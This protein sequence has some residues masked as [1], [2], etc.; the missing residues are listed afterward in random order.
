M[1]NKKYRYAT[2]EKS[3]LDVRHDGFWNDS[4]KWIYRNYPRVTPNQLTLMGVFPVILLSI[5]HAVGVLGSIAF[6][7]LSVALIWYLNMDAMDGK[8]ARHSNRSS[9]VGQVMD[10]GLDALVGGLLSITVCSFLG[11]T[12]MVFYAISTVLTT[13]LFFQATVKEHLTHEM[14]VS[15][16]FYFGRSEDTSIVLSTTELIYSLSAL[17]FV[18]YFTILG[19]LFFCVPAGIGLTFGLLYLNEQMLRQN[20]HHLSLVKRRM[21]NSSSDSSSYSSSSSGNSVKKAKKEIETKL[22]ARRE[23][24]DS[25]MR[26]TGDFAGFDLFPQPESLVDRA[27]DKAENKNETIDR[28]RSY[29]PNIRISEIRSKIEKTPYFIFVATNVLSLILYA[30][31]AGAISQLL[32]MVI[33]VTTITVDM[34]FLNTLKLDLTDRKSKV[35][36]R[37]FTS[38]NSIIFSGLKILVYILGLSAL[39]VGIAPS[40]NIAYGLVTIVD[41]FFMVFYAT[42]LMDKADVVMTFFEREE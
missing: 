24:Y 35:L 17:F 20:L 13:S 1:E 18:G 30:L 41:I 12:N 37:R 27:E 2:S 31:T 11:F 21:S 19:D 3:F 39:I 25:N 7:L 26:P 32:M 4:V 33:Y 29:L 34:I 16:K 28:V 10:H 5:L 6:P 14:L 36:V 8:L 23:V 15:M 9:P 22:A 40:L 38:R 42:D